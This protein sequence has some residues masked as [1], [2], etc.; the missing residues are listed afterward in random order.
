G[1]M[2][3]RAHHRIRVDHAFGIAEH[4]R[5]EVFQV[6][7]VD[8]SGI[9]RHYAEI[10]ECRLTPAEQDIA[11]AVALEFQGRVEVESVHT[12]EVIHLNGVVDDQVGGQQRIGAARIGAHGGQGVAHGGQ[13]DHARDTGEILQQDARRHEA[14][15][16]DTG[17]GAARHG[18]HILR[19]NS[20]AVFIAQEVLQQ[21]ADGE[22]QL[23]DVAD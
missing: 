2:G 5:G 23:P 9:G 12:A 18:G 7:L 6:Y 11:F 14:D 3:I 8:D 10:A 20:L 17:A 22:R 15:L 19:G 16:F 4:H 1:G 21:Y 13:V